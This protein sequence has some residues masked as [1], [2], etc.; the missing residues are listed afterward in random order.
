MDVI[1]ILLKAG[2]YAV[3]TGIEPVILH[4]QPVPREAN[5]AGGGG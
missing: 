5:F 2:Y 1:K 4:F 3:R